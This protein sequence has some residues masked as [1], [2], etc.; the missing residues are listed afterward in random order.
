MRPT[1]AE[2]NLDALE[3]N[4]TKIK[5]KI[6]PDVKLLAV[7]KAEAYG[8]G[9][10]AV[11]RCAEPLVD[12]FGVA[13][14]SEG[15]SLRRQG[16]KKPIVVLGG[17]Y[18]GE[19]ELILKEGLEPAVFSTWQLKELSFLGKRS[20]R[21]LRVHLKI[22]TGLG[23]LGFS[24]EELLRRPRL[25]DHSALEFASAFTTLASA[26]SDAHPSVELQRQ[27]FDEVIDTLPYH[28][29][30][31]HIANSAALL[32][33]RRNHYTMVR[34]GIAL[35]GISPFG[36]KFEEF[37]PVMR[38]RSEIMFLKEVP[39]GT[40]L[41]YNG[42]FVTRRKSL[43]ATV[44]AGYEDGVA[45]CLSNRGYMM[46]R[47][48]RAPVVGAVSMDLTLIDVTEI[49]G[50]REGDEVLIFQGSENLWELSRLCGTIP[51]ELLCRVGRRVERVYYQGGKEVERVKL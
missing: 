47:G 22:D 44:P 34:P 21:T 17:F 42:T 32:L 1:V 29:P 36:G 43:I 16:I 14:V 26:G 33:D 10:S 37:R 35:Y 45:R 51:Y 5:E 7:V 20:G 28:F 40:P 31:L 13:T 41:G 38:Y 4:I 19:E 48:K 25:L 23:R 6:G 8:H 50:V 9:A 11:S 15:V 39:P 46:V 24:W 3:H 49:E 30:L 12:Y 27:R 2:I 18:R